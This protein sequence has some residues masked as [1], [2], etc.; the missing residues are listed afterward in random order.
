[1]EQGRGIAAVGAAATM[2]VTEHVASTA[3]AAITVARHTVA[4]T[5]AMAPA[6]IVAAVPI[7]VAAVFVEEQSAAVVGFTVA[8]AGFMAV[9]DTAVADA[10][11]F[12]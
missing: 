1:L 5:A 9:A 2:V 7:A 3:D 12:A 6:D 11:K 4:D 10:G 8:E